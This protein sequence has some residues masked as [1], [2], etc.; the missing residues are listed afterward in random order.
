MNI[1]IRDYRVAVM[2]RKNRNLKV[3]KS[4][5]HKSHPS[6]HL[7]GR[8]LEQAGFAINMRVDVIVKEKY[9]VIIPSE[10]VE[11]ILK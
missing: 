3:V 9:L 2:Q 10:A 6:L 5:A 4:F 1:V 11:N 8:W 7:T